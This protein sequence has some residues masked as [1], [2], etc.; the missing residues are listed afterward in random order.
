M[1]HRLLIPTAL[2]GCA[3]LALSGC[4]DSESSAGGKP[5]S[6]DELIAT[7]KAASG[8]VDSVRWMLQAEPATLDAD[9]DA[10]DIEDS[11]LGNMCER[12][13][14]LQP[15]FSVEP[16]LAKS[17]ARP[18]DTTIVYTLRDDV[19]FHDGSPMTADDVVWS[20]QRHAEPGAD[21]SDEYEGVKQIE[22]TGKYEVTVTLARPDAQFD[23]RMAGDGGII[24]NRAVIDKQGDS[25]GTPDSPDACSGPYT[26]EEWKAGTSITLAAA[27]DYWDDSRQVNTKSI[28]FTWG[29]A[30]A[31]VNAVNAGE[32]DGTYLN[33]PSLVGPLASNDG[34]SVSYGA[35]TTSWQ[36]FPSRGD[37]ALGDPKVRTALSLALNREDIVTAAFDGRS[38]PWKLPVGSGTWGYA[39]DTFQQAY[40]QVDVAP[41]A[42]G[43][44]DLDRAKKLVSDAGDPG[45]ITIATNGTEIQNVMANG[46]RVAA[47]DI[48]L[49]V[50]ITTLSDA[51]YSELYASEEARAKID[52]FIGDWYLSKPDP[53]G[54]YDNALPDGV[55]NYLGFDN[56][57]YAKAYEQA[58]GEYDETKRA[59]LTVDL[60][61]IYL[62]NM[63]TIPLVM[64]PNTLVTSDELTGAPVSMAYLAYPWAADLGAA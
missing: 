39:P 30:S 35:T 8:P 15:D 11:V 24:W 41:P 57:A 61:Q 29:G 14:Q 47:S 4:A 53:L 31:V 63:V 45:T 18:D 26:L 37:G 40:D 1:K 56:A 59:N 19:T 21:E 38:E 23:M 28:T 62:D 3:A 12:L 64:S 2:L 25:F 42:P 46:V 55:N 50:E 34:L 10:G 36:V 48:G 9:V 44:D 6:D 58:S 16:H 5:P 20:L 60:Q 52:G 13:F 49:D 54:M 17:V 43:D 22:K 7:T 33:D 32:A 51:Q 27:P